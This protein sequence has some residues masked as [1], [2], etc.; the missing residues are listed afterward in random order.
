M[1]NVDTV[2]CKFGLINIGGIVQTTD[3]NGYVQATKPFFCH[4][5]FQFRPTFNRKM[6]D[7]GNL[8][9]EGSEYNGKF[10]QKKFRRQV[11][12]DFGDGTKIQGYSVK[13]HY[14]R[15]G[16]YTITCS[17]FD[18]NRRKYKNSY[19][20]SVVVKEVIPTE[21]RFSK[22]HTLDE[23]KCSK[24][25]KIAKLETLISKNVDK[26]LDVKAQRIFE[27]GNEEQFKSFFDLDD[28]I[29]RHTRKHWSFFNNSQKL[30]YR[31]DKIYSQN[32]KPTNVLSPTYNDI[33]GRFYF[34]EGEIKF[35]AYQ[36]IPYKNIDDNL[37]T[38][39]IIDPM[40]NIIDGQKRMTIEIK[41][42]YTDSQLPDG[43]YYTGKRGW[44]DVFYKNDF[45][46]GQ[47]NV[48]SYFYNTDQI[49]F[50]L[51]S[52]NYINYIPLGHSVNVVQND[53]SKVKI[54]ISLDGFMRQY[55]QNIVNENYFIDPYL[56]YSIM[57]NVD[58][59]F[60]VFPFVL[61]ED[62]QI[63]IDTT[64]G[65]KHS[66]VTQKMTYYVPKDIQISL[67]GIY[68]PSYKN[69]IGMGFQGK[70][71]EI[72]N[73][74]QTSIAREI[75]P[76]FLR[77]RFAIFDYFYYKLTFKKQYQYSGTSGEN[78]NVQVQLKKRAVQTDYLVLPKDKQWR[79]NI[80]NLIQ[81]YFSHPMFEDTP[82][83]KQMFSI[84]LRDGNLLNNFMTKSQN[85]IDDWGNIQTCYL[86]S[87]ISQ[88]KM[89]G[90][91]VLQY[92]NSSFQGIND[93]KELVRALSINHSKL[94]GH[95]KKQQPQIQIKNDFKGQEVGPQIRVDDQLV[96]SDGLV[97]TI[98]RDGVKSQAKDFLRV[99]T[100]QVIVC[101]NYTNKTFLV[102]F[103]LTNRQ[104]L[105]I[106]EYTPQ[107]GWNLLLP[108][109]FEILLKTL[110][111][112]EQY[113]SNNRKHLRSQ[114]ELNRIKN[115]IRQMIRGYYSFYLY[116][117]T[118]YKVRQGNFLDLSSITRRVDDVDNWYSKWGV[119][120][121]MLLKV[122]KDNGYLRNNRISSVDEQDIGDGFDYNFISEIKVI[123]NNQV[124]TDIVASLNM[125]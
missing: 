28:E 34:D 99:A 58:L 81:C 74:D 125:K 2:S 124:N 13:H 51:D 86:S 23:I 105:K 83:L 96:L 63:L 101:D 40:C 30:F 108:K 43:V 110:K 94:V 27:Q 32:L 90:C 65:D 7:F 18:I 4:Q 69:L 33:Y 76:W 44:L 117:P 112:Q 80:D 87:F 60:Y 50:D 67:S 41:Q 26:E 107:W 122:I 100:T 97:K 104:T 39:Q 103:G 56:I 53:L 119:A 71:S 21:L 31:S 22:K 52:K 78:E 55:D 24:I 49:T 38:I 46:F 47:P 115:S 111:D 98:F 68:R 10:Y 114:S 73:Y 3:K 1:S 79:Q 120:H 61:Y 5:T 57:T 45:C 36:V 93:F 91:D 35:S 6:G 85:F 59:D 8:L 29:F 89:M 20:I 54:G 102:N 118:P 64:N 16:Q 84:I 62:D 17:F 116:N 19:S 92:E 9:W 14:E 106:E 95:V 82:N 25:E 66:L 11:E 48:F 75:Q 72:I 109:R 88:M 70:P 113:F 121:E 15:A 123:G 12:W 37:K 77:L 42:V